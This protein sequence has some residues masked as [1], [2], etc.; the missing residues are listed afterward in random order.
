MD[1]IQTETIDGKDVS[2]RPLRWMIYRPSFT[3]T[4]RDVQKVLRFC[5]SKSETVMLVL[6]ITEL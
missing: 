5:L 3:K 1:D 4:G 2:S 6:L